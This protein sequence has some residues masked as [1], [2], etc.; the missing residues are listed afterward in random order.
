MSFI[1][2]TNI[3]ALPEYVARKIEVAMYADYK[4]MLVDLT[5]NKI[6]KGLIHDEHYLNEIPEPEFQTLVCVMDDIPVGHSFFDTKNR[7]DWDKI[8]ARIESAPDY[9]SWVHM[10]YKN[11]KRDESALNMFEKAVRTFDASYLEQC[12]CLRLSS[13]ICALDHADRIRGHHVAEAV[14]YAIVRPDHEGN[15]KY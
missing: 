2:Q 7:E 9:N 13:A 11:V 12:N 5:G 8:T 3:K 14:Q 4:F 10:A 1:L 15:Y 6:Y